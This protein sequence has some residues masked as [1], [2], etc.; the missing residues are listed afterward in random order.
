MRKGRQA[1]FIPTWSLC[2]I[3]A[4]GAAAFTC[5][6]HPIAHDVMHSVL[7]LDASYP[8]KLSDRDPSVVAEGR[9]GRSPAKWLSTLVH[10]TTVGTNVPFAFCL[11]P[12]ES[13]RLLN[14]AL[15]LIPGSSQLVLRL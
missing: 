3:L 10:F 9:Q 6:G 13:C 1:W 2:I 15:P 11:P 5:V 4:G 8:V 14:T 7:C 12:H